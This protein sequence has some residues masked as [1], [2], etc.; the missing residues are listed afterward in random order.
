MTESFRDFFA[1]SVRSQGRLK[2]DQ[3]AV[4]SSEIQRSKTFALSPPLPSHSQPKS[5]ET[6]LLARS[7]TR[8]LSTDLF[9]RVGKSHVCFVVVGM[10]HNE[11][12]LD[13]KEKLFVLLSPQLASLWSRQA[14]SGP[15]NGA[16]ALRDTNLLT[17]LQLSS[18][19]H[20]QVL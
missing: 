8:N 4:A 5:R 6:F 7:V 13:G 20:A 10:A 11:M 1:R 12:Q 15:N 14:V 3:E 16:R 18:S 17:L 9:F 19:I 2:L